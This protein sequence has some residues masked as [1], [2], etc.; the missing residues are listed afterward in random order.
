[1]F[2]DSIQVYLLLKEK[3]GGGGEREGLSTKKERDLYE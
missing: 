3:E 1:M 2:Y